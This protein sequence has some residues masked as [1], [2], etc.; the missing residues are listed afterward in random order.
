MPSWLV[1]TV[2]DDTFM[3]TLPLYSH[4]QPVITTNVSTAKPRLVT[5]STGTFA[6]LTVLVSSQMS[7]YTSN[8]ENGAVKLSCIEK[9]GNSP[10]NSAVTWPA[11]LTNSPW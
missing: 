2:K 6:L 5:L 8:P 1:L 10:Q 4:A 3:A 7:R 11:T 9:P